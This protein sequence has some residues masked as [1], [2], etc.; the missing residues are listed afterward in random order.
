MYRS[1]FTCLLPSFS[2]TRSWQETN[3]ISLI[4][5]I[6]NEFNGMMAKRCIPA[7]QNGLKKFFFFCLSNPI[8]D[9]VVK[10][11]WFGVPRDKMEDLSLAYFSLSNRL[12]S[13]R[14]FSFFFFLFFFQKWRPLKKERKKE[15]IQPFSRPRVRSHFIFFFVEFHHVIHRLA[16]RVTPVSRESQFRR[17][18]KDMRMKITT[19]VVREC[20]EKWKKRQ[21][22]S[23][24]LT[25]F[26]FYLAFSVGHG[27]DVSIMT[28]KRTLLRCGRTGLYVS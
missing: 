23:Q 20:F 17:R 24:S 19:V 25:H 11:G 18:W 5:N 3:V 12:V 1:I 2:D 4:S 6:S 21:E 22:T 7:R 10:I 16:S 9:R 27:N 13:S 8:T 26:F 14:L 28:T 15:N